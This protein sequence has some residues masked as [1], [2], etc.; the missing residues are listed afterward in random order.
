MESKG[1]EICA[2]GAARWHAGAGSPPEHDA[3]GA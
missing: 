1:A 3:A 2:E